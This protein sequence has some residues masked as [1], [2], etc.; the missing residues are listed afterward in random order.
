VDT[1]ASFS[2]C[3]FMGSEVKADFNTGE[4]QRNKDGQFKWAVTVAAQTIPVNGQR[5]TAETISITIPAATDP[6]EGLPPGTMVELTDL[7]IGTVD[8]EKR[9]DRIFGGKPYFQASGVR[10]LVAPRPSS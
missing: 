2:V 4:A 10:P 3:I 9:G 5:S 8:P 1:A 6:A 7:R